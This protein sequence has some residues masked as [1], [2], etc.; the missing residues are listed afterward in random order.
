MRAV[1]F[2]L[3]MLFS[4]AH[5]APL[6]L[7]FQHLGVEQ[8]LT[9][10]SVTSLQQDKHGYMWIG[11]QAGLNR[12]D[13]Y[14]ITTFK[15]DPAN[16]RSLQDNYIQ[17]IY[18]DGSGQLWVG[19]K[20]GLDRYDPASKGFTHVLS[21][22][23]VLGMLGDGGQGLWLVTGEGLQH[24]D[25][26]SGE[27]RLLRHA[28]Q[29]PDS[30]SDDRVTALARDQGG[31]LW[32]GTA[33][34]L[35]M[36][37]SGS[38]QF[39]HFGPQNGGLENSILSLSIGPDGVLW[40]GAARGVQ[41]W[42]LNGQSAE[43]LTP[44]L[45][46]D[47]AGLRVPKLLHDRDGTLWLGTFT[48]GLKR[49]DAVTGRFYNYPRDN[50]SRHSISDN[51]LSAL[52][53]DRTGTLWVGNWFGGVDRVDLSSG[54][55]ERYT[56]EA[57]VQPGLGNK[58]VRSIAAAPDGKVW[59]GTAGGLGLLDPA[60]GTLEFDSNAQPGPDGLPA[61]TLAALATDLRGRLWV[62]TPDGLYW[63]DPRS[64]RY[65]AVPLDEEPQVRSIQSLLVAR[66]GVIWAGA[67]QALHR[68]DPET[69][70]VRTGLPTQPT[71]PGWPG[72]SMRCSKTSAATCGWAPR[73]G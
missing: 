12:F 29:D 55:F 7:R 37:P 47:L 14:R 5:A 40:A 73:T 66:D 49:R 8:G 64:G 36:L 52:Y 10:E 16:P 32:I 65:A 31:N 63:R 9:Q 22:V 19:S 68:V 50:Q 2:F 44:A 18:E 11:T 61:D 17:T 15:N 67:R 45:P 33:R 51:Q 1:F 59:L 39:R 62:G 20:G 69:L 48:E 38:T 58:K 53:Q 21:K 43:R 13:G 4:V 71:P 70:A 72:A 28:E 60:Q 25:L 35:E 6:T 34:G 57:G 42:R 27:L 23:S 3:S 30:I 26:R 56:E 46:A 41:A 24:L 54:G